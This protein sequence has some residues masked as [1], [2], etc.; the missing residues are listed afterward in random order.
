MT[1]AV[2]VAVVCE[3]QI[4]QN[5]NQVP[6][7][8]REK[9]FPLV[10]TIT[11]WDG[12]IGFIGGYVDEGETDLQAALRELKEEINFIPTEPVVKIHKTKFKHIELVLFTVAVS[13]SELKQMV[14]GAHL[15]EH[16]I[17]EVAGLNINHWI[18]Y[19]GKPAFDRFM[20]NSHA[21]KLREQ[22]EALNKH[23]GWD[24]K[25]NLTVPQTV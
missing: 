11:R 13:Y 10:A 22:I 8:D 16:Y 9:L 2:F 1:R 5:Y 3:A 7:E 17:T 14:A 4:Y 18:N 24:D 12:N 20:A 15:A 19:E 23:Y 21:P 6:A 25:Y